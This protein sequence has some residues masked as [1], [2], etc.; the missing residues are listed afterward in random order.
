MV[1]SLPPLI[2]RSKQNGR[3]STLL[4][5]AIFDWYHCGLYKPKKQQK[6]H[7][8]DDNQQISSKRIPTRTLTHHCG[9]GM[10]IAFPTPFMTLFCYSANGSGC[11]VLFLGTTRGSCVVRGMATSSWG[12]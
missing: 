8:D 5:R 7:N 6:R 2:K 12:G 1:E 10:S 11:T 3:I 4:T 9:L